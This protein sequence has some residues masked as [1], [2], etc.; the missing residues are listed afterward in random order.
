MWAIYQRITIC[1]HIFLFLF[2]FWTSLVNFYNVILCLIFILQSTFAVFFSLIPLG[3]YFILVALVWGDIKIFSA[4]LILGHVN[5]DQRPKRSISLRK[6]CYNRFT[7]AFL[8]IIFAFSTTLF[9]LLFTLLN[10]CIFRIIF[11]SPRRIFSPETH[12]RQPMDNL[13]FPSIINSL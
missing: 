4:S 10:F 7:F 2:C 9:I 12:C 8:V 11:S 6:I 1:T 3:I 5:V 13:L